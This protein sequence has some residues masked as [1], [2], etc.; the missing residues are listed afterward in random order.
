MS[1]KIRRWDA[2]EC[3][4]YEKFLEMY[5][6][7]MIDSS[8]KRN[9][10]IF[11]LMSKFIRSKTPSQCRSHHQKFF[12]KVMKVIKMTPQEKKEEIRR[13]EE[14]LKR[15]EKRQLQQLRNKNKVV[16]SQGLLS[17]AYSSPAPQAE[18][19]FVAS[20]LSLL[21]SESINHYL[22]QMREEHSEKMTSLDESMS[23][24]DSYFLSVG[25]L[26]EDTLTRPGDALPHHFDINRFLSRRESIHQI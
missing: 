6:E 7:A 10:R 11:L 23:L 24:E 16:I 13:R 12:K 1:E 18:V 20:P 2:E 3:D 21:K 5:Y 14:K 4:L 8:N 9:T 22:H 26:D 17:P 19:A 25:Q 15:R